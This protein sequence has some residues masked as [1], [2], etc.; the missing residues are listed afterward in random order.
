MLAEMRVEAGFKLNRNS[1][2]AWVD[3]G[4]EKPKVRLT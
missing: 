1:A 4:F 2:Q 3:A